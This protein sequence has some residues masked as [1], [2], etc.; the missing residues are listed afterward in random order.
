MPARFRAYLSSVYFREWRP[1]QSPTHVSRHTVSHGV[2]PQ[3]R[4]DLKSAMIAVLT[5]LQLGLYL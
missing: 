4:F 2:A 1:G 5:T 3:D